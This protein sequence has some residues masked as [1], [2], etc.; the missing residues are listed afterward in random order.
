MIKQTLQQGHASVLQRRHTA[1]PL[2]AGT[3]QSSSS[4]SVWMLQKRSPCWPTPH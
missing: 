4:G 1:M 3:A 2:P